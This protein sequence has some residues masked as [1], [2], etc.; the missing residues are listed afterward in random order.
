MYLCDSQGKLGCYLCLFCFLDEDFFKNGES[1]IRVICDLNFPVIYTFLVRLI[2][3]S[4]L[5]VFSIL[6]FLPYLPRFGR[7][8]EEVSAFVSLSLACETKAH[9]DLACSLWSHLSC[10]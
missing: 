9:G 6:W 8:V 7:N 2:K 4:V 10:S 3:F 5:E 1:L